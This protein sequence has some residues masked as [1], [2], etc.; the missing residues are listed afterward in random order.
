LRESEEREKE[1]GEEEREKGEIREWKG[2]IA[3]VRRTINKVSCSR[4]I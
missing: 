1:E 4:E 3:G 2:G